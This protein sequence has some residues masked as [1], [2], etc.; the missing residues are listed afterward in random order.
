MIGTKPDADHCHD[1]PMSLSTL[2]ISIS[3]FFG[4]LSW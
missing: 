1:S 2:A 4:S 3:R